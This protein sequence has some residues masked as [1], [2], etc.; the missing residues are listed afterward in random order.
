MPAMCTFM[1]CLLKKTSIAL[2]KCVL[3]LILWKK[4]SHWPGVLTCG[5]CPSTW[6]AE[7]GGFQQVHVPWATETLNIQVN[8]FQ[9]LFA[10]SLAVSAIPRALWD[11]TGQSNTKDEWLV[12]ALGVRGFCVP[13]SEKMCSSRHLEGVV[14]SLHETFYRNQRKQVEIKNAHNLQRPNPG[15]SHLP[16]KGPIASKTAPH[17]LWTHSEYAMVGGI[18]DSNHNTG[19][20]RYPGRDLEWP[21]ETYL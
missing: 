5:Y 16:P 4:Y 15:A 18:S 17:N 7:G 6:V 13:R 20:E 9:I 12:F 8:S 3:Y 1:I 10:R 2:Q 11:I 19:F 21:P 14:G